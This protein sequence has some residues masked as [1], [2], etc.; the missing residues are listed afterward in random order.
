[1]YDLRQA[2]AG[3][4]EAFADKWAPIRHQFA[5]CFRPQSLIP[6]NIQKWPVKT[7]IGGR[8]KSE[9]VAGLLRNN[10]PDCSGIRTLA[11]RWTTPSRGASGDNLKTGRAAARR[12]GNTFAE[13]VVDNLR[14]LIYNNYKT[15]GDTVVQ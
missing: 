15:T 1:L 7:R 8:E 4:S 2:P 3:R 11:F 13:K 5:L 6:V 10:W 14:L 12:T 9:W